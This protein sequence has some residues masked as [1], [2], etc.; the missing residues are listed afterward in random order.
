M[1]KNFITVNYRSSIFNVFSLMLL[2]IFLGCSENLIEDDDIL[3]SAVSDVTSFSRTSFTTSAKT[4]EAENY[5]RMSGIRTGTTNDNGSSGFVGWVASGDYIEYDINI[6]NAGSYKFE[7]RV[8]S[9]S[10]GAKFDFYQGTKKLSNVN[11]AATGNWNTYVTTS[12]TVNLS[13]GNSTIK[14]LATGSGWNINWIKITP[15]KVDEGNSAVNLAQGK[16]ATQ[17]STAHNGAA[18]RAV[19]GNTSGIY[20]DGSVTHTNN[21]YQPWWQVQLGANQQ[22]GEIKIWNRTNCCSTRLTNFD[23]FV[24]NSSG[25]QV[26]KKTITSTPSP[27]VTINTGGV[28]GS[29]VRIKLKGTNPLSLAEVQVFVTDGDGSV[30]PPTGNFSRPADVMPNCNQ[31]KITYPDGAEDKT[32]CSESGN[33]YFYVNSDKSGVVFKAPIRNGNGTTPNSDYVRSELRERTEDGKSDIF[34]TTSGKHVVY[35]K[36]AITHLPTNKNHLVATQIHG[37]KSEG[38]DDSMVLRLEGKHLFLSFNGGKLRSNKTITTNYNLGTV[39]E[40]IFEVINGK[41][42]C[43]YATNGNLKSA[44]NSGNASSYLVK[45]GGNSYVM[46]KSYGEA[47]FKIGNYTQSNAEEEGSATGNSNNYG[48]V[49]VYDLFV[50]HN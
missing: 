15:Q 42:Y 44:Y 48:E 2:L 24:Y 11:K 18:S 41:H 1:M 21:S 17:S 4:I 13:K 8:S 12:K 46:N 47:Y 27:S 34:W 3:T 14:I 49:V 40:V 36:Q 35:V 26:F 50:D 38:I 31:W 7:F 5:D 33:E 9:N 6:A 32:L 23:V 45:D 28:T 29:R 30:T 39:H 22:I 37:N 20:N 19:D 16:A 25:S 10:A 43:Y